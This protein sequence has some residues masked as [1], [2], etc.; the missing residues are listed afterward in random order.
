MLLSTNWNSPHTKS[1]DE[2]ICPYNQLGLFAN[3]NKRIVVSSYK[4]QTNKNYIYRTNTIKELREARSVGLNAYLNIPVTDWTFF[5]YLKSLGVSDIWVDA[6]LTFQNDLL[7]ELKGDILIRA[8]IFSANPAPQIERTQYLTPQ[9]LSVLSAIDILEVPDTHFSSYKNPN[10]E[11]PVRFFF[12]LVDQYPLLSNA[13]IGIIS[14][15]YYYHRAN[16]GQGCMQG[17]HCRFCESYFRNSES[18][19]RLN[20]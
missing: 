19:E 3:T 2:V 17:K 18:L 12:P 15:E 13:P 5:Q 20:K 9:S 1:A 7:N 4:G 8:N 14:Q 10:P 11:V 6:P 16:C